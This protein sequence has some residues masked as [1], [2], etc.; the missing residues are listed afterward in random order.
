MR[1]SHQA[2]RWL[3]PPG[4]AAGALSSIPPRKGLAAGG[5]GRQFRGG[6]CEGHGGAAG[7]H[8]DAAGHDEAAE[9]LTNLKERFKRVK[10]H[11]ISAQT[12]QGLD[13]LRAWLD[14]K[15]GYDVTK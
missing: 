13:K 7:Q 11:P 2:N 14:E 10:I 3:S 12:G 1:L 6:L 15:I 5:A 9:H 8:R 4:A